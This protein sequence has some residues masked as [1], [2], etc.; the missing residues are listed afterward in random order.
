[1]PVISGSIDFHGAAAD[2]LVGV[3][4]NRETVLRRLNL[5]VPPVIPMRLQID[6]GSYATGLAAAVFPRLNITRVYRTRV[7]TTFTTQATPYLADVYDVSVTLVSGLTQ[8]RLASV[9]ALC[10]PDFQLTD[11]VHRILGR[12]ILSN[13]GFEY[14][15]PHRT[16][17]LF[18]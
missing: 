15:G 2:V 9:H 4:R 7:R 14:A 8:V 6:T 5:P 1:M 13:C 16:F 18:F 17:R 12:D 10:S 3:S 11:P